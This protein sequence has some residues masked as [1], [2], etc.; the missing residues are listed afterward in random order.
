MLSNF[1][2][3]MF[4]YLVIFIIFGLFGFLWVCPGVLAL[5]FADVNWLWWYVL[6]IPVGG[7]IANVLNHL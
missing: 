1:L 4:N 3:G 5:S 2:E 6:T 7:G